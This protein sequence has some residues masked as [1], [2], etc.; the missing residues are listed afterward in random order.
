[1]TLSANALLESIETPHTYSLYF[2]LD[3]TLGP[4]SLTTAPVFKV[5]IASDLD[6]LPLS[7]PL[8]NYQKLFHKTFKDT[9]V[10]VKQLVSIVYLWRLTLDNFLAEKK[11]EGRMHIKLY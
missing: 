4:R 10:T 1:V 8:E 7:L 9:K 5:K 2:G 6:Q 3:Y 11:T